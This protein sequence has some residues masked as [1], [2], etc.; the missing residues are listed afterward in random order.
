MIIVAAWHM[1]AFKLFYMMEL[2]NAAFPIT[3]RFGESKQ[4]YTLYSCFAFIG[5]EPENHP[6]K[7]P[8][9]RMVPVCI[10]PSAPIYG[11]F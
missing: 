11:Y 7:E 1:P 2:Y 3:T 6:R 8:G 9:Y 10:L 5:M 4:N